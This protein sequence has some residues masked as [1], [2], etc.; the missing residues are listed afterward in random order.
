MSENLSATS[1]AFTPFSMALA[2]ASGPIEFGFTNDYMFRAVME[3]NRSVLKGLI[4]ALLHL[5]SEDVNSVIVTNANLPGQSAGSKEF[6]LDVEVI[7]NNNL[8]IN[9][10]MQLWN[11]G[12]W[13]ERSLSY[14]C[15]R[16]DQLERGETYINCR[17]AVHIGFLDFQLFPECAEFYATYKLLN[18]RNYH[19]YSDKFVLSV[20]DLSHIDLA[21]DED[22]S[23][24]IDRWAHLFKAK[25]WE[26]IKMIAENDTILTDASESLFRLNADEME[27]EYA[28]ARAER[29]AYENYIHRRLAEVTA[30][31]ESLTAE[32]EHL[33]AELAKYQAQI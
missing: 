24:G 26:E 15:R 8:L 6:L 18:I 21:T 7:L 13:P 20:V 10:E 2:N 32:L 14:L 1:A 19:L 17:P 30:E 16:F 11:K 27:R 31:N 25:T 33:R 3:K 9:L 28:R 4:C 5:P 12:N 22:K 29:E 23:Y